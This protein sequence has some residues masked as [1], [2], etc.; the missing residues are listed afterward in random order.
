MYMWKFESVRVFGYVTI[1][2][3]VKG[4]WA[5]HHFRAANTTGNAIA[6]ISRI[7]SKFLSAIIGLHI[8]ISLM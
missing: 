8:A 5:T 6:I 1:G 4:L 7:L 3:G 2:A